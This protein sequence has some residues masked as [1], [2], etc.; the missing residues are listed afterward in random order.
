MGGEHGKG[1]IEGSGWEKKDIEN[2]KGKG[3]RGVS[4]AKKRDRQYSWD[5]LLSPR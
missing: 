4:K 2:G 5:N 3:R 1:E